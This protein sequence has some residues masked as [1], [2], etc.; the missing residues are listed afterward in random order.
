MGIEHD[1]KAGAIWTDIQ[2]APA[3]VSLKVHGQREVFSTGKNRRGYAKVSTW[4]F[5]DEKRQEGRFMG[6]IL[7][8]DRR[9]S[10]RVKYWQKEGASMKFQR[11]VVGLIAVILVVNAVGVG[12]IVAEEKKQTEIALSTA[13]FNQVTALCTIDEYDNS[14][15]ETVVDR[16]N[17]IVT[18]LNQ[19]SIRLNKFE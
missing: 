15:S 9:I 3:L 12:I 19:A 13:Q 4:V 14:V 11:I 10:A 16:Y 1:N 8:V 18:I 2:N 5:L 7:A 17:G 6:R